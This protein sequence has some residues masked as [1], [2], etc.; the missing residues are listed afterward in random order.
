[1]HRILNFNAGP[2]TLPLPVLEQARDEFVE[3]RGTGMS[4]VEMSH[5]AKPYEE[6]HFGAVS[7]IRE[8][9]D[10]PDHYKV[11]FLG[12]GATLQFAMVPMNLLPAGRS[13][14]FTLTGSWAKKA[15]DDARKIGSVSVVYDG[16]PVN[17][18]SLPAP[19]DLM[20]DPA[21][22]YLH[23]TANETIGGVQ[24]QSFPDAGEVPIVCDMSSDFLSRRLPVD[25]FGL[26]YAGAQKNVGPAGAT[27]VLIR[28]D[29]LERCAD[30]LPAYLD[31]RTHAEGDSLYNTPPVF[32][33]Y[34]VKL[35]LEHLK[36][37]GGL[38]AAE[39]WAD[40]RSGLV[41]DAIEGSGGFYSC[42]VPP[43]C[44]SKMNV[45]FRLPSEALEKTFVAEAAAA[46][47]EG[48]KGHRSVGGCRASL[49]NAMPIAGAEALARFMAEFAAQNG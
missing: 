14:D 47:M 49:Y 31:Y 39:K 26:I 18:L 44:R 38:A 9:L 40:Q 6:V 45:V 42:P 5:R 28:D 37:A 2:S 1:M 13:C 11:L 15:C 36:A 20:L 35:V 10:L 7:L 25:R 19:A 8:L 24:W 30:T 41:Y 48:L 43:H 46:G 12:G 23:L 4:I 21:A 22:A 3:F 32:A 27:V 33:L 29:M 34:M 16:K 17:Y